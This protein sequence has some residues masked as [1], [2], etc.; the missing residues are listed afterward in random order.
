MNLPHSHR[1][2]APV[3]LASAIL[4]TP[5]ASAQSSAT[6]PQSSESHGIAVANMDP[7]VKPGDNFYLYANG[8]WIARTEIPPDRSGLSVFSVLLDRSNKHV[9]AI[10][11]EEAKSNPAAG[12]NA[13]K[14]ADVYNAYMDEKSIDALGTKPLQPHLDAIAAIH[15]KR[16]LAVA[17]GKTL[18]ADVDLLNNAVFSTPNFLG[19]WVAPG[20]ADSDH[21]MPYLLQGGLAMP[22]PSYYLDGSEHMK[23]VRAKYVTHVAAMLKFAGL[24]DTDARAAR[25]VALEHAMAEVHV[26]LSEIEDIAKANNLWHRSDFAAKAPGLD[27]DAYFEGTGLAKQQEFIR[28]FGAGQRRSCRGQWSLSPGSSAGAER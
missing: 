17:L 11:E 14:I 12:S 25:V 20:F 4:C 6:A 13:R 28:R 21:Y 24:D 26:S 16:G 19:L 2:F 9:A 3:L 1:I 18:R 22:S 5:S 27:W 8:G 15:D 7:S 23:E 10:I